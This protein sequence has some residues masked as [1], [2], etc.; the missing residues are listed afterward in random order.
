PR[1][2]AILPHR[3][4]RAARRL[5]GANAR[6][7]GRRAAAP[8]RR[9]GRARSGPRSRRRGGRLYRSAAPCGGRWAPS[10]RRAPTDRD[11]PALSRSR[12]RPWRAESFP[13]ARNKDT[14]RWSTSS[15][16]PSWLGHGQSRVA[17]R[18][19][20]AAQVVDLLEALLREKRRGAA[21]AHAAVA[22]R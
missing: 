8:A 20:A 9:R 6:V 11:R 12:R 1:K 17:P 13:R 2:S 4:R 14:R 16:P 3:R 21:A 7:S 10:S 15:R 19:D 18:L 5:W 22:E